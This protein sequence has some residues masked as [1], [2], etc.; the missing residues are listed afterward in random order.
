MKTQEPTFTSSH[1]EEQQRKTTL[2]SVHFKMLKLPETAEYATISKP[3]GKYL[4][5]GW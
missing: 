1:V 5:F 4:S 2:N 3:V